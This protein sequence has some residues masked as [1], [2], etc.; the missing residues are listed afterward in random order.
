MGKRSFIVLVSGAVFAAA[1]VVS[2]PA[3]ELSPQLGKLARIISDVS[4]LE[5][6]MEVAYELE[7]PQW[8]D[9]LLAKIPRLEDED[10]PTVRQPEPLT[11]SEI[12]EQLEESFAVKET[13]GAEP[14]QDA[15]F[16]K[17]PNIPPLY[18][19]PVLEGEGIW[20]G[21]NMPADAYGRPLLYK[22]LYRPS[23]EYPNSIVHLVVFDMKRIKPYFF[24]GNTE[25]GIYQVS[26]SWRG[27]EGLSKIVA[28][29]NA[30]WMQQHAR[31]AGAI[32]RGQEIYPMV[33]GMA[34]LVI[35]NDDSVDVLEWSKDVP[36]RLVKDA[37]Q[38]RH[39]IVKDGK[40]VDRILKNGRFEDSEIGLGGFLIDN[41]GSST[42]RQKHWFLANRSAFGIR[43]D[44]NLVF[45]LAHHTSTKDLAKAL[46]LAGCKRAIHG[47]ANIHNIVCNFYFRDERNK[48]VKRDK[49]SPEQKNYT[50]MRYDYGYAKDYFAF[51]EK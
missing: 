32:F 10:E 12:Q 13:S 42:M 29:T 8:L 47:D 1:L 6:K 19:S 5:R 36:I 15:F 18:T 2:S 20:T 22:T 39:L 11:E 28:I 7:L 41:N 48:I 23:E 25:P 14:E 49:L 43:D 38:L 17:P 26:N 44:G 27:D 30:M 46:V 21:E 34:T 31:G 24:I 9:N 4:Q 35:Y 50:M 45:A 16:P 51:Y 3:D 40:V 37:R 33:D